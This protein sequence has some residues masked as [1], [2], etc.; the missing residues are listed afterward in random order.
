MNLK[1]IVFAQLNSLPIFGWFVFPCII[2]FCIMFICTLAELNRCPFDLPEAESELVAGYNTEYSGMRF[3]LFFLGEYAMLFIMCAFISTIFFGGFL[4]ITSKYFSEMFFA[5]SQFLSVLIYFEQAVWLFLKTFILVFF[6]ILVRATLPRLGSKS[7]MKF[8]W[9]C[10]LPLSILNFIVITVV[11][12][13][14][15]GGSI[16]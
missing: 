11:K 13:F 7:L 2:G 4:P 6:V 10:L 1:D 15:E 9:Y 5:D 14:S 12:Y 16:L 3:A 8:S